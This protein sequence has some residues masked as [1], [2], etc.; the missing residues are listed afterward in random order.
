VLCTC[1]TLVYYIYVHIA[2]D[3]FKDTFSDRDY[4]Y[5]PCY[6]LVLSDASDCKDGTAA[7]SSMYIVATFVAKKF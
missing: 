6:P 2:I 1:K 3:R 4:Y 5:N 7:V